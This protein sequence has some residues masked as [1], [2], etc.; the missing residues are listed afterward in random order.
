MRGADEHRWPARSP[1][2]GWVQSRGALH[3]AADSEA[4]QRSSLRRVAA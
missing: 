1:Q 4:A 2:A 3:S